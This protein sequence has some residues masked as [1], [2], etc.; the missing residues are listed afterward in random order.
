MLIKGDTLIGQVYLIKD[1][2]TINYKLTI[3]SHKL[4]NINISENES[5]YINANEES[6][7]HFEKI[8]DIILYQKYLDKGYSIIRVQNKIL[9]GDFVHVSYDEKVTCMLP[10]KTKESDMNIIYNLYK[11]YE[12]KMN[13]HMY[14]KSQ[15][16]DD[17]GLD[18]DYYTYNKYS[19]YKPSEVLEKYLLYKSNKISIEDQKMFDK[20]YNYDR[21]TI[22]TEDT[23]LEYPVNN[24]NAGVEIIT[25]NNNYARTLRKLTHTSEFHTVMNHIYHKDFKDKDIKHMCNYNNDILIQMSLGSSIIW[26]PSII[27]EY[28]HQQLISLNDYINNLNEYMP[29]EQ[30]I[31]VGI[32]VCNHTNSKIMS[33]MGYSNLESYLKDLPLI[34]NVKKR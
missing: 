24:T 16:K 22:F 25:K 21:K 11:N 19:E 15:H 34:E 5:L 12:E 14:L 32:E 18:Y 17:F 30:K 4:Q 23:A 28:Q 7:K 3:N 10:L 27:N 6:K 2:K 1:G 13:T 29:K 20:Y 26:V 9:F 31:M 8:D 33:D